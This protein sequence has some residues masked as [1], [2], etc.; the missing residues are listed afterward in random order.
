MERIF[1][2]MFKR[3]TAVFA[4]AVMT[5]ALFTACSG[6][7]EKAKSPSSG[8]SGA[9]AASTPQSSSGSS[10]QGS[11]AAAS[12]S[13]PNP[14]AD[15]LYA[16][17]Y[18]YYAANQFD[19]SVAVCD[20]AIAKD[21]NC[22]WAYN[23]KGLAIYFAN[24]NSVA[25]SCIAL[26]DK[27]LAIDPEYAFAYFN[28]ARILKGLKRWNDSIDCFNEALKYDPGSYWSYYG[29]ATIYADTDQI[30]LAMEYLKKSIDMSNDCKVQART[31][32]HFD[33]YHDNPQFQALVGS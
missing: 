20:Q 33:K 17:A 11:S 32:G 21:P 9:S 8:T 18:G 4:A 27:S 24:G 30:D 29:I 16:K 10:A 31:E 12:S 14:D 6:N 15:P 5:A 23:V 13:Y 28:K 3:L 7:A 26:I 22:F 1:I 19:D 2:K 25:D